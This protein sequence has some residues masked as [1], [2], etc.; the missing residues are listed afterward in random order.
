[1]QIIPIS[2]ERS[3]GLYFGN[4]YHY[5]GHF[6]AKGKG[7]LIQAMRP[8]EP[9]IF[10]RWHYLKQRDGRIFIWAGPLYIEIATR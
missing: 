2:G 5:G 7:L 4:G 1:M 8:T 6:I 9:N 10:R 3:K